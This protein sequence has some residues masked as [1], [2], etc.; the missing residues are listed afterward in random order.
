MVDALAACTPRA[1]F[2]TEL[3]ARI[4][5]ATVAGVAEALVGLGPGRVLVVDHASPDR[6][7]EA[8]LRVLAL[9]NQTPEGDAQARRAADEVWTAWLRDI[10]VHHRCG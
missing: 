8:D 7:L 1:L 9:V 4:P 2:L 3:V 6:H 5:G 10:L